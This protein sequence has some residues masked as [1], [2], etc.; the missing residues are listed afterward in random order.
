MFMMNGMMD[1]SLDEVRA[2]Y[3]R[4]L[5][6]QG[7]SQSTIFTASSDAFYLWNKRGHDAF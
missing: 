2:A 3:K 7:L 5:N 1:C 6:A 4:Y